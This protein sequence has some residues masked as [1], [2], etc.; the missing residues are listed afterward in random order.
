MWCIRFLNKWTYLGFNHD[1][2]KP[3]THE[4]DSKIFKKM[5]G[6]TKMTLDKVYQEFKSSKVG[7][8]DFDPILASKALDSMEELLRQ[9]KAKETKQYDRYMAA[10][11]MISKCASR[12]ILTKCIMK[13]GA[14]IFTDSFMMFSLV[15]DLI[16]AQ[17]PVN[18]E[19]PNAYPDV[20]RFFEKDKNASALKL[21]V[22]ELKQEL[23]PLCADKSF[24]GGKFERSEFNIKGETQV[25]LK[26]TML[27]D[28]VII[29]G[30]KNDEEI[31]LIY[32]PGSVKPML[33]ETKNGSHGII[34]PIRIG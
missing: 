22:G 32:T 11:R 28:L 29:L 2:K 8:H 6:E 17:L 23:R 4:G 19:N 34:L 3:G 18:T 20:A 10:S 33:V 9:Q 26:A 24:E 5:K 15:G 12:P 1:T 25:A 7:P 21:N 30:F 31:K 27:R 13:D 16:I 14:Q